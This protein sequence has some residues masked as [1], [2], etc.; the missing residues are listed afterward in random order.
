MRQFDL[1]LSSEGSEVVLATSSDEKHPPENII[2]GNPETFWT[3]TGMFPQEFIICFHKH[4]KVE[5]LIIQSYLVRT[6]KIEKTK[7]KEPV[8]FERWI[9]RD[10]VHTEGQLQNEEI[11]VHDGYCTYLRFIITKAFDHFIS[12]HCVSAEGLV[13]SNHS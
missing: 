8:D 7:S 12:V 5:K 1:C 9:E 10:F 6:L 3:T 2:D 4:V 11:L 13:V